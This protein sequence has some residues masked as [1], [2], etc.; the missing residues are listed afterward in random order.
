MPPP[1][2]HLTRLLA[3][4]PPRLHRYT[5]TLRTAPLS[6]L[7]AFLILHELTAIAPLVGLAAT[8]HYTNTLPQGGQWLGENVRA[9]AERFGRWFGRKGWFGFEAGA[10]A[11]APPDGSGEGVVRGEGEG[12]GGG[13]F[14]GGD[15]MLEKEKEEGKG[16]GKV[17]RSSSEQGTKILVE[18]AT[19]YAIT[20]VLLPVRVAVSVWATPWFA[21][22]FVGRLGRVFALGRRVFGNGGGKVAV[23]GRNTSPAAGTGAVGGGVG[24]G[25]RRRRVG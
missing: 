6:H 23:G 12:G 11:R 4:L 3:R 15:G 25:S 20:K 2:P 18:V 5:S 1:N 17:Y 7:T 21:R 19:A 16:M 24:P 22:V 14:G 10:G 9:G 8:F 13:G